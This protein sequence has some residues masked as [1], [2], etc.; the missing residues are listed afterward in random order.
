AAAPPPAPAPAPAAAQAQLRP[1]STPAPRYPA[2]A[3]RAG[4]SGEVQVEFTVG[5]DGS[6]TS[7][8]VVRADPPRI[9]DREALAAV[10]RW[11]FEPVPAPVTTRRT[12]GFSPQSN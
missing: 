2:D 6:V 5:V 8:R 12:I 7:A 4:S 11:R 1:L 10:R 9:F 3:L